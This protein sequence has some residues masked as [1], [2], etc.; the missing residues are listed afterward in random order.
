MLLHLFDRGHVDQRS[1][2]HALLQPVADPQLAHRRRQLFGEGVID[3]GLHIDAVGADA[4]LAVVA[5]LRNHRA[6]DAL[7]PDRRRRTR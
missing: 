4:G 3:A 7:H 1:E 2:L 5:E 6:L